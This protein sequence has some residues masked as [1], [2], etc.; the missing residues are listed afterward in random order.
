MRA[1]IEDVRYDD[2]SKPSIFDRFELNS[3]TTSSG[4]NNS[5]DYKLSFVSELKDIRKRIVNLENTIINYAKKTLPVT[6]ACSLEL[7]MQQLSA[8]HSYETILIQRAVIEGI[9]LSNLS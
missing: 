3:N 5:E 1:I 4:A 9:D 7:L 2:G 8:M 6:P